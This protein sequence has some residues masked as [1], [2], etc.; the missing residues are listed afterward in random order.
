MWQFRGP[1]QFHSWIQDT[2]RVDRNLHLITSTFRL[3]IASSWRQPRTKTVFVFLMLSQIVLNTNPEVLL[4]PLHIALRRFKGE[5]S[6]KITP[7]QIMLNASPWTDLRLL[8]WWPAFCSRSVLS[9][10]RCLKHI[11]TL[12]SSTRKAPGCCTF[13]VFTHF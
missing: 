12:N 11:F 13:C 6:C 8:H 5:D 10:H 1:W 7:W 3:A 9:K 2:W 4:F